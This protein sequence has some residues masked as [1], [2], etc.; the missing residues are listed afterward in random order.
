MMQIKETVTCKGIDQ[1]VVLGI[2]LY[3]GSYLPK[4]KIIR[5]AAVNGDLMFV[6]N[7]PCGFVVPRSK[8]DT[9]VISYE[10]MTPPPPPEPPRMRIVNEDV[11]PT[12]SEDLFSES[13]MIKVDFLRTAVIGFFIG[14]V[15]GI[16][17]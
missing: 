3:Q 13:D 11:A 17:F 9:I 12:T 5:A 1:A 16:I 15:I 14:F 7:N 4:D 2:S 6:S 8:S 10:D